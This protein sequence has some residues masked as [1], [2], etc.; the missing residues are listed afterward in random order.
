[1]QDLS[2]FTNN[3]EGIPGNLLSLLKDDEWKN[4]RN[5]VTPAFTGGKLRNMEHT[6]DECVKTFLEILESKNTDDMN[7]KE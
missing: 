4:V 5:T 6:I 1:M 3:K 2:F 7:I